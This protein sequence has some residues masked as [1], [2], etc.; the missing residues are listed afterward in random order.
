MKKKRMV[1]VDK[2]KVCLIAVDGFEVDQ[3]TRLSLIPTIRSRSRDFLLSSLLIGGEEWRVVLDPTTMLSV[4]S[5]FSFTISCQDGSRSLSSEFNFQ[6][7][8]D[9]TLLDQLCSCL[10]VAFHGLGLGSLRYIELETV[11]NFKMYLASIHCVL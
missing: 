3:K 2:K 1:T 10:E 6:H 8:V 9:Y 4:G 5:N 7:P 11:G